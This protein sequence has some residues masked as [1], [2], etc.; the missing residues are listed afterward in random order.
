M[1][2]DTTA[3]DESRP[4][5]E[6]SAFFRR[7]QELYATQDHIYGATIEITYRCNLHCV[8]C[9]ALRGRDSRTELAIA[10]IHTIAADLADLG[11]F[12][13]AIT[14]GEPLLGLTAFLLS[15][16]SSAASLLSRSF[17]TQRCSMTGERGLCGGRVSTAPR[18]VSTAAAKTCTGASPAAEV[19]TP[20]R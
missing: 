19:C 16:N 18:S 17:P 1:R 20:A 3:D 4:E 2:A 7:I 6:A 12:E 15:G 9:Y 8:H 11:A 10:E 5:R 14:G 13:V